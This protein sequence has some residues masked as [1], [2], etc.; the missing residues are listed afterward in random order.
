[1]VARVE[2]LLRR[3]IEERVPMAYLLGEAWFAGMSFYVDER[4][5]IPRS[6]IAELISHQF[7]PLLAAAPASILDICCG[8]GCIGIACAAA[9]PDARVDLSD[10]SA[11]ALEVARSNI[12]RHGFENRVAVVESDLFTNITGRYDLIIANPPYVGREEYDAL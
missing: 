10:I 2:R 7:E 8:S 11:A 5:L 4:V 12:A 9:F 1:Q 3:R 6:P